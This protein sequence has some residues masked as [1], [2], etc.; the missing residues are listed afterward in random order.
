LYLQQFVRHPGWDLRVFVVGGGVLAGMRRPSQGGWGANR[1]AGGAGGGGGG[2]PGGGGGGAGGAGGGR[3]PGGR[4]GRAAGARGGGGRAASGSCWRST[5]SRD[6]GRWPRSPA[7][8]WPLRWSASWPTSS[9]DGE[10]SMLGPG[11][12]AVTACIWEVTARK[13]GNVHRYCD[14]ADLAYIDFLGS[15][16]AVAPGL[17]AAA[18]RPVGDTVLDAVRA[19]RRVVTTNTNLGI[20]LLLAPLAAVPAGE[21]LRAGLG[22]ILDGLTVEDARAVYAAIRLAVPGGMGRVES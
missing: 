21:E 8:T 5:P 16:A 4:G 1:G 3:G 7:S 10:G 13:P 18:S 17:E 9:A 20:V 2:G 11:L 12:S 6:G 15:A 14:F 22:R 19:T